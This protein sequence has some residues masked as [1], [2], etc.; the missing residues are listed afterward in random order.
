MESLS[1][2]QE[3]LESRAYEALKT[4][5]ITGR[6]SAGRADRGRAGG[7]PA[8]GEPFPRAHRHQAPSGGGLCG[9]VSQ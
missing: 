6:L 4:A 2:G 1:G 5:I 8:G 9:T 3:T 7:K